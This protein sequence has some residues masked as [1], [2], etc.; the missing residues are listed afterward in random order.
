MRSGSPSLTSLVVGDVR[1]EHEGH[2][3]LLAR[4]V[5]AAA[6]LGAQ[7]VGRLVEGDDVEADVHV[8][9][10]VDPFRQDG[11]AVPVERCAEIEFDHGVGR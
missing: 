9:V 3:D 6:E 4:V 8:A 5:P 1:L 11:G 2:A 10:P 7:R